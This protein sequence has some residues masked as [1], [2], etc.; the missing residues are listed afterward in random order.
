MIRFSLWFYRSTSWSS[1]WQR[2]LPVVGGRKLQ[3]NQEPCKLLGNRSQLS[4][5]A[6]ANET[7]FCCRP[8]LRMAFLLLLLISATWLLGLMAVNNNVMIFHY[9]FAVFSC[10]Q[11][12]MLI[13]DSHRLFFLF[14]W[15]V[16]SRLLFWFLATGSLH[17]FLS[18]HLQ[19]GSEK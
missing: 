6:S 7:H 12:N 10:L 9:L 15:F 8:A 19:H 4:Q 13:C 18:H 1:S 5:T 11:V 14:T 3:R 2:K 17:L 16:F